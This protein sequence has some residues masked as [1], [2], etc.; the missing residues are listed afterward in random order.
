MRSVHKIS[1]VAAI[2]AFAALLAFASSA[3]EKPKAKLPSKKAKLEQLAGTDAD[4]NGVRDDVDEFISKAYRS[5]AE[6]RSAAVLFARSITPALTVDL[7]EIKSTVA[8]AEEEYAAGKCAGLKLVEAGR[9]ADV[10]QMMNAV[11]D[12]AY[13]TSARFER[14]EVFRARSWGADFTKPVACGPEAM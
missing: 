13:N 9:R 12:R 4:G 11:W 5:D 3:D 10:E 14:R 8:M 7:A 1:A 6:L 2:F